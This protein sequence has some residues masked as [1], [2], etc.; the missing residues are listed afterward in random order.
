MVAT[1]IGTSCSH[2]FAGD[3]RH[4]PRL[5]VCRERGD[6]SEDDSDAAFPLDNGSPPKVLDRSV[7]MRWLSRRQ[8]NAGQERGPE[9]LR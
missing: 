8:M 3:Y 9:L 1:P 4:G 7:M 5:N 2:V 6:R